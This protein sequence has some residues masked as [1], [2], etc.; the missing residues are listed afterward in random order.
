MILLAAI[1]LLQPSTLGQEIA[2]V[3]R[4]PQG[5]PLAEARVRLFPDGL[6]I[7]DVSD[8]W[9]KL[10]VDQ[11]ARTGEDGRFLFEQ[12][13]PDSP[14]F[15]VVEHPGYRPE[16]RKGVEVFGRDRL[17]VDP[18]VLEE[19][20]RL[21]G[22]VKDRTGGILPEATVLALLV[23]QPCKDEL[24]HSRDLF[25][26]FGTRY[27]HSDEEGRFELEGL[28][29]CEYRI[30]AVFSDRSERHEHGARL[31]DLGAAEV[32]ELEIV[33]ELQ[34]LIGRVVDEDGLPVAGA[35]LR[36][37]DREQDPTAPDGVPAWIP[38]SEPDLV[39]DDEGRFQSRS[40]W[41]RFVFAVTTASGLAR[42]TRLIDVGDG[43]VEIRLVAEAVLTGRIVDWQGV[44]AS[45]RLTLEPCDA[46]G[47]RDPLRRSVSVSTRADRPFEIAGLDPGHYRLLLQSGAVGCFVGPILELDSKRNDLTEPLQRPEP[48]SIRG[49]VVLPEGEPARGAKVGVEQILPG[50][51]PSQPGREVLADEEGRFTFPS[52]TSGTFRVQARHD[53]WCPSE[54]QFVEILPTETRAL[55]VRLRAGGIL[56]GRIIDRDGSPAPRG[57][58]Q[59]FGSNGAR[60]DILADSQGDFA[61]EKLVPGRYWMFGAMPGSIF[62]V[63]Q[64]ASPEQIVEVLDGEETRQDVMLQPTLLRGRVVGNGAPVSDA[65]VGMHGG[66]DSML[67]LGRTDDAGEFAL[68]LGARGGELRFVARPAHLPFGCVRSVALKPFEISEVDFELPAGGIDVVFGTAKE[69]QIELTLLERSLGRE[70]E[71]VILTQSGRAPVELEPRNATGRQVSIL[72]LLPGEYRVHIT[73][74]GHPPVERTVRVESEVVEIPIGL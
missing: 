16:L 67:D 58:I 43:A 34:P 47:I 29:A 51:L 49:R 32:S 14:Y 36:L 59:L 74:E 46:R 12:V 69:A 55:D 64:Q 38:N 5:E 9:V 24:L 50:D 4:D 23:G 26:V 52:L 41:E 62:G 7:D 54:E 39:T 68:P 37:I 22:V 28:E 3:V 71:W 40:R 63:L 11:E 72:G 57:A 15:L 66:A 31:V 65:I 25:Q 33:S 30:G 13:V 42:D 53:D 19:G 2:G 35:E 21:R 18:I 20:R 17:E 27:A 45:G 44:P 61:V 56:R 73:V 70:D 1:A 60:T 8:L 48:G 6:M 10:H